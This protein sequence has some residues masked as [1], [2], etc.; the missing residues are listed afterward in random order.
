M[1]IEEGKRVVV[2]VNRFTS[3]EKP[4]FKIHRA[5]PKVA[6][7]MKARVKRLRQER[8]NR[9]V[10]STLAQLRSKAEGPE[11][12]VPFVREAVEAYAT[13]GEICDVLRSV[14]GEYKSVSF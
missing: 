1:E 11:N 12:L 5:D 3:G 6:Q 2:G 8:D 4:N 13:M 7:E 9:R 10:E 14:F